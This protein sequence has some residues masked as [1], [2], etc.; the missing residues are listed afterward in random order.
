MITHPRPSPFTRFALVATGVVLALASA[1]AQAPP[2]TFAPGDMFIS[3]E[4]APVQWRSAG[5][6]LNAELVSRVSGKSE[7]MRL[8]ASGNLYVTHWCVSGD[9]TRGNTIERF[10]N[11]GVSDGPVGSGYNCNP[12]A[13]VFDRAGKAYV[14]QADCTGAVLGF[15][16]SGVLI[17]SYDVAPQQR[18]AFWI[19]LAADGCTLGYTS[20]GSDVK[21]FDVC[22]NRQLPNFNRVPLPGGAVQALVVLPDGGVLVS[23]GNVIVRLDA[24]GANAQTYAITGEQQYWAGLDLAGDGTFWAI[25]YYSSDVYRFNLASGALLAGFHTGAETQTAVDIRIYRPG[26]R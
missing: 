20:W 14:G 15:S 21:R 22:A 24:S 1:R 17:A 26:T 3:F 6:T 23:S 12:H 13:L 7:G 10:N 8:D 4:R 11:Q 5:G 2:A 19:D 18:G 9:C 16:A 25:N